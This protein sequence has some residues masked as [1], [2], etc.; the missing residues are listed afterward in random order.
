[1]HVF[2]AASILLT[3]QRANS[4]YND[5]TAFVHKAPGMDK[6]WSHVPVMLGKESLCCHRPGLEIVR[7]G[8]TYC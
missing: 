5:Y 3:Q 2:A 7:W 6:Y 4:N 8:W 1:M